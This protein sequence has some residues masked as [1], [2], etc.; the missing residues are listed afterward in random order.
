[1][2]DVTR[3]MQ[4]GHTASDLDTVIDEV[5]TARGE[6]SDL[7]ARLEAIEAIISNQNQNS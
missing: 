7:N 3:K 5:Y 1:M 6:Y 2:A 4:E